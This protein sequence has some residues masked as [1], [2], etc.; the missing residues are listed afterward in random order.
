MLKGIEENLN[1]LN[2]FDGKNLEITQ[3]SN[4][5]RMNEMYQRHGKKT[6]YHKYTSLPQINLSI[7]NKFF[8]GLKKLILICT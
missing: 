3:I 7:Q 8:P 1:K 6:Q 5:K 4:E 2:I